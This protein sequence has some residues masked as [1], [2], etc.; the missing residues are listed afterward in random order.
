M[1][2]ENETIRRMSDV[3]LSPEFQ[4]RERACEIA[5]RRGYW[6]GIHATNMVWAAALADSAV[7]KCR[8][9]IN[10]WIGRVGEWRDAYLRHEETDRQPSQ[11]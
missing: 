9:T 11:A 7:E 5:Y 6:H 8:P 10:G 4:D 1:V 3:V 2:N